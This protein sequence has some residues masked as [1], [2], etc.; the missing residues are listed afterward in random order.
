[1]KINVVKFVITKIIKGLYFMKISYYC[2]DKVP[3]NVNYVKRHYKENNGNII[4]YGCLDKIHI[5]DLYKD[6]NGWNYNIVVNKFWED[7]T[8][9]ESVLYGGS[10]TTR[11]SCFKFVLNLLR[12]HYRDRIPLV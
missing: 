8:V 12:I 7:K 2:Y 4:Y 9:P 10:F 1:M 3:R 6:L 5:C 11:D